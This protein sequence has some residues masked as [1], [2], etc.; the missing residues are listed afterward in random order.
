MKHSHRW[1]II[2]LVLFQV[3]CLQASISPFRVQSSQRLFLL[4]QPGVNPDMF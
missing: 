4:S 1:L 2:D 3:S